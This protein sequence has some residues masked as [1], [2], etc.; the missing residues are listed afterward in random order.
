M[1]NLSSLPRAADAPE[2]KWITTR[3]LLG[4]VNLLLAVYAVQIG[5]AAGDVAALMSINVVVAALLGH[6]LLGERL[7]WIHS[8]ALVCSG[9]VWVAFPRSPH[10]L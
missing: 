6:F 2:V 3:A 8:L 4:S 1:Y 10:A 5:S 7:R 9:G